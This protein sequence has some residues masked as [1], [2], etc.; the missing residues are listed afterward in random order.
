MRD[1]LSH[2]AA[3]AASIR[4]CL[5]PQIQVFEH[6]GRFDLAAL[7]TYAKQSPC[8]GIALLTA[9]E[10]DEYSDGLVRVEA[11]A[12]IATKRTVHSLADENGLR[13]GSAVMT[14]LR[15][16]G[17]QDGPAFLPDAQRPLSLRLVNLYSSQTIADG[18]W[19]AAVTWRQL[20]QL[21]VPA[22]AGALADFVQLWASWDF[23]PVDPFAE[24][25]ARDAVQVQAAV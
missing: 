9:T 23:A 7:E 24:P 25:N 21:D 15:G 3:L 11:A 22:N 4:R 20:V 8:V 5:P 12:Y 19:L 6:G 14:L 18:V 16:A 13:L 1:L 10:I 17:Y 2:R